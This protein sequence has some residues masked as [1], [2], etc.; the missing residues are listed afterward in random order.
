MSS[1]TR[2]RS[3]PVTVRPPATSANLGP[4]FDSFGL[5]LELRDEV[6]VEVTGRP[7]L[8][9]E[10]TGEG[11]GQVPRDEGHLLVRSLRAA[12][13]VLGGQPDGLRVRCH[14]RIPH[15]RGLGSSSAAICAG[16]AAARALVPAGASVLDDEAALELAARLE[17]HPDNVA[18]ALLGGLTIAWLDDDPSRR[19]RALRLTPDASVSALAFIPPDPLA[20]S[21]ARGLLPAEVPHRDAAYNAGRA[22]LLTAALTAPELTEH[23]RGVLLRAATGDRLHQG[24]RAPSMP[25]SA[26]LIQRLRA[27][28]LAAFVSGAGPS[29]LVLA[30]GDAPGATASGE[31]AASYTPRGWA[32]AV[33]PVAG[34]GVLAGLGQVAL[35]DTP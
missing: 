23:H 12:F 9:V 4:G 20:T 30:V 28:G 34:A 14:N 7:G 25:D 19:A 33:L 18:P 32:A 5:A 31:P 26:A 21:V 6:T 1:S 16:I 15:G 35:P 29:V 8:S 10:V 13:D 24:Y 3:G 11:A 27:D 17:G 22:G 2:W